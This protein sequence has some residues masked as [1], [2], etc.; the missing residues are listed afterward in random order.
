MPGSAG[1][2]IKSAFD[3]TVQQLFKPF[4]LG[5]WVR[6]AV[7]G[8]L[9]GELGSAGGCGLQVPWR[10]PR[11]GGSERFLAQ[12]AV[13]RGLFV[14][15]G[16]ALLVALAV[17]LGIVLLYISSRMR[18]VLFK[19]VV[20]KDCRIG[21]F[22]NMYRSQGLQYFLFQILFALGMVVG[23]G[24]LVGLGAAIGFGFG[25]LRNPRDHILPLVLGGLVFGLA[26]LIF[27]VGAILF[28]VLTKDFVVPQMALEN[29][30]VI[31]GWRRLWGWLKSETG[32]YAGY[33]GLK[34]V[35]SILS[36][37]VVGIAA[38][39]VIIIL[40]IPIGLVGV[41]AF[42]V[43]RSIGLG[44][45]VYT[46]AVAIAAGIVA[47]VAML[48]GVFLVSTPI[49]VF[50]PAYAIYFLA[51]RYPLLNAAVHPAPS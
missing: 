15:I 35:L 32:G 45:N 36:S 39:A 46:M 44:W 34:I 29:V 19:S 43:G 50:F 33:V 14:V 8:L 21:D 47:L 6:L 42:V 1:D 27:F 24:S 37:V 31:E 25:W 3:Q 20:E 12:A 9:A 17:L 2:A 10:P 7:T 41:V 5:Q 38:I 18:F 13:P 23:I 48:C 28:G 51:E 11:S 30:G 4:R 26:L 40:L 16:I 49:V 22:W